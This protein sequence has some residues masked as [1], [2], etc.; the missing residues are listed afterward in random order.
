MG[1]FCRTMARSRQYR[2]LCRHTRQLSRRASG[3]R[4]GVGEGRGDHTDWASGFLAAMGWVRGPRG[5]LHSIQSA[6]VRSGR[7]A[8][9]MSRDVSQGYRRD[10][11][12]FRVWDRTMLLKE[13]SYAAPQTAFDPG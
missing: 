3:G 8:D 13:L 1:G 7:K 12:K 10:Y 11:R 4:S 5:T 9:V 6:N 2:L